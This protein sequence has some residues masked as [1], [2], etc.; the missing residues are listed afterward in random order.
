MGNVVDSSG[1]TIEKTSALASSSTNSIQDIFNTIFTSSNV[2][3]ILWFL[4][5]Y[6]VAYFVMKFFFSKNGDAGGAPSI[7]GRILDALFLGGLLLYLIITYFTETDKAKFLQN[8]YSQFTT[9]VNDPSSFFTAILSIFLFYIVVYLFQLPMTDSTKPISIY[10][11][12]TVLWV[13]FMIIMFVDFFKYVLGV[14][15]T[16]VLSKLNILGTHPTFSVDASGHLIDASGNL[17]DASGNRIPKPTVSDA[18]NCL[19]TTGNPTDE[20]FNVS[21]N[22]YTYSD[23][24]AVCKMYG[25]KLATY[26]QIEQAYQKGGEWCNYGWSD[27]Q[28]A[29]FPTQKSTWT[30]LQ[31]TDNHKNDC[32][33]PGVN[34]G[35]IANPYIKFGVNCYGQKPKPT[36]DDLAKMNARQNTVYPQTAADIEME[37]KINQWKNTVSLNSYNNKSWSQY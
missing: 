35:F 21:N 25:A 8:T 28:M 1:N 22:V 31:A 24:Q 12:E 5:I 2:V 27:G 20:V 33:R 6:F 32:G 18:S 4:A 13:V 9:Y 15:I 11:I 29:F 23:A 30:K 26:D 36:A 17:V 34:G 16:D 14:S 19:A 10:L 37:K 7:I 3:L